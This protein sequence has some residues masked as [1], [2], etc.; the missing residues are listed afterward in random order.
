MPDIFIGGSPEPIKEKPKPEPKSEKTDSKADVAAEK[1]IAKIQ[2]T[3]SHVH[4]FTAYCE[5]PPTIHFMDKLE[6]EE[7]LLFLRKHFVTNVPWLIRALL[8]A[9]VP[10]IIGV[11][12]SL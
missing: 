1:I 7:L 10:L 12:S 8:L 3:H 2:P 9:L 5:R 11:I 6:N 4:V